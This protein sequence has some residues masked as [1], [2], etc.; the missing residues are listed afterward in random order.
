MYEVQITRT[1]VHFW[2]WI[3][4]W[5]EMFVKQGTL[6]IAAEW[7]FHLSLKFAMTGKKI[8][9][10]RSVKLCVSMHFNIFLTIFRQRHQTARSNV[11][12]DSFLK[13]EM[14]SVFYVHTQRFAAEMLAFF[15]HFSQLQSVVN[16]IHSALAGIG[17]CWQYNVQ[18]LYRNC[19]VTL[20]IMATYVWWYCS[21][22]ENMKDRQ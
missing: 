10:P 12:C 16:S 3:D 7:Y 13:L 22:T 8:T 15:E 6:I 20:F 9:W 4:V 17:V 1:L 11:D 21:V 2:L 19:F 18:G 14:P 5:W